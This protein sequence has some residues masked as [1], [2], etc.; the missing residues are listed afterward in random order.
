MTEKEYWEWLHGVLVPV[1]FVPEYAEGQPK[2]YIQHTNRIIGTVR[3][4]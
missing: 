1:L 4:R 3:F 2:N